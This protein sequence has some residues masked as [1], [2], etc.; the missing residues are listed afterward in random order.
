MRLA[1]YLDY[2][3]RRDAE[4]VYAPRAFAVFVGGLRDEFE[5]VIVTGRVDPEPGRSHYPIAVDI[6]FVEMPHYASAADAVAVARTLRSAL[7]RWDAVLRDVDVV[8]VLGPQG[9]A[10]PLAVLALVR[11][12]RVVLGVRQDL[13]AYAR[14]RHPGRRAVHVAADLLDGAF[15]ALARR[16]PAI[17]VGPAL[18]ARYSAGR[19]V[20]PVTVSLVS[21]HEV[22]APTP[23]RRWDG[24]LTMISVG[25]LEEEKN[26]LLLAEVLARLRATDPRWRLVVCG[27][28]PLEGALRARLAALGVA[29][30]AELRGYLPLDEGLRDAYR[31]AHA[32]LH[33]SRTE[34]L[35]Q[36]LFEA[37]AA[38]LPV[39]ATAVGG[40]PEAGG[41]AVLLVEP[42][43]VDATAARL[44]ELAADQGLRERLLDAGLARV[45]AH[46]MEAELERTAAF[47]KDEHDEARAPIPIRTQPRTADPRAVGSYR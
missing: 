16:V 10:L 3:H 36:V 13:A 25:R 33:V 43:D 29:E 17:V 9:L 45:R 1:V 23:Q 18:A 30:A 24:E 41:D 27:E 21:E 38:R 15:R 26:P 4:G 8:W 46:T 34:G 35:P 6:E 11:G 22:E 37:F 40:V 42:E 47:L 5:R 32:F 2:L 7:R 31:E 14:A 20:L 12:K 28:G 44:R 19:A 39:V